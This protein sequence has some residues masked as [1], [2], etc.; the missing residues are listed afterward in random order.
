MTEKIKVGDRIGR[1]NLKTILHSSGLIQ[2]FEAFDDELERVVSLKLINHSLYYSKESIECIL[3]EAKVLSSLNHP[4]ISKLLDF[5][6]DSDFLFIV[7]EITEGI[8]LATWAEIKHDWREAVNIVYQVADAMAYAHE[9]GVIHRDLKPDNIILNDNGQPVLH[10]FSILRIIEDEET[11]DLTG[12]HVGLS[13]PEYISP[14]QG[15]GYGTD[16]R[17]DIYSLGVI[18]FELATGQK[19]FVAECSMEYVIQHVTVAPPDPQKINSNIPRKLSKIILKALEKDVVDR[20]QSMNQFKQALEPFVIRITRTDKNKPNKN[21]KILNTLLVL[22]LFI[23]AVRII[24]DPIVPQSIS[25]T[26][27]VEKTT[28]S[29]TDSNNQEHAGKILETDIN[30]SEESNNRN[31]SQEILTPVS[32]TKKLVESPVLENSRLPETNEISATNINE[33]REIARWGMPK[34]EKLFWMKDNQFIIAIT[35]A[36]LYFLDTNSLGI[37]HFFSYDIW[38]I[39]GDVSN[40]DNF[41]ATTDKS[42]N[43]YIIDILTGDI[44]TT[45]EGNGKSLTSIDLSDD[46]KRIVTC[47]EDNLIRLFDIENNV[48]L[49]SIAGRHS[50]RINRIKFIFNQHSFITASADSKIFIWNEDGQFIKEIQTSQP[51]VDFDITSNNSYILLTFS[52]SIIQVIDLETGRI[53]N[54]FEEPKNITSGSTVK[55]LPNDTLVLSSYKN[56]RV[57][58]WN[59]QGNEKIWEVPRTTENEVKSEFAQINHINLSKDG[60]LFSYQRENGLI[61]IWNLTSKEM[62]SSRKYNID[63]IQKIFISNADNFLALQMGEPSVGIWKLPE[64]KKII[65]F[66]DSRL[67]SN[68]PFSLD[69][70]TFLVFGDTDLEI[71]SINSE[72]K[73]LLGKFHGFSPNNPLSILENQIM[74]AGYNPFSGNLLLWSLGSM[75]ELE[76]E[77]LRGEGNCKIITSSNN[78]FLASGSNIGIVSRISFYKE[79]CNIVKPAKTI[80]HVVY[81][82]GGMT[83]FGLEENAIE[84]W[85]SNQG[86]QKFI[87]NTPESGKILGVAFSNNGK[88]LAAASEYGKVFIFNLE[89]NELISSFQAHNDLV[90]SIVFSNNGNFLISGSADGTVKFWGIA[91]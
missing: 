67:P 2:E 73:K 64:S 35:R 84:I 37:S 71:Y 8:D 33:L 88:L 24:L 44:I 79:F 72:E 32:N 91:D 52:N 9:K 20:F 16:S 69:E 31:S 18:L 74:I 62:V 78:E 39:D 14:E 19:P 65:D 5:G 22:I 76:P 60:T 13:S 25:P 57:I 89:T 41:I 53:L 61:E 80:S 3:N 55:I 4:N 45:F 21:K 51:I 75:R 85:F 86:N 1:Y 90:S 26:S 70:K 6:V 34:I 59:L 12:T 58:L 54:K 49:Y 77:I 10:D 68:E 23:V 43:V 7:N 38:F 30:N 11:K 63:Q 48:Q 36:G 29:F 66:N 87:F 83:A 17:S 46:N 15:K 82:D 27:E 42:G 28:I 40:D 56:G 47:D 81:F 50:R